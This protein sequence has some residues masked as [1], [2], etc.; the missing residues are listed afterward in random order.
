MSISTVSCGF[1][2]RGCFD[3]PPNLQVLQICPDAP[4]DPFQRV[5]RKTLKINCVQILAI[6]PYESNHVSTLTILETSFK[7]RILAYGSDVQIN[8]VALRFTVKFQISN[9]RGT[10]LIQEGL[11]EVERELTIIPNAILGTENERL[12]VQQDLYMDA[13]TQIITQL[14][15]SHASTSERP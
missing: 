10:I 5:L 14:A 7:E 12:R 6:E 9:P 2:L 11:A 3:I 4:F 8:R 1:K 13:T 15:L